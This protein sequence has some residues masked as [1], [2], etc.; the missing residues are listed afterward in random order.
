MSRVRD[1]GMEGRILEAAMKVFGEKGYQET[2]L[3]DIAAGAGISSGSVYTYFKDKQAL[4]ESAVAWGWERFNADLEELA[5][6]TQSFEDRLQA[7]LGRGLAALAQNLS[8]VRGMLF[9]ASK[10]KLVQPGLDRAVDSMDRLLA[11]YFETKGGGPGSKAHQERRGLI[12]IFV[13]GALFSAGLSGDETE[14]AIADLRLSMLSFFALLEN[15]RRASKG[16][17]AGALAQGGDL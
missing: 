3:K 5:A 12:K 6:S 4:F 13:T 10:S 2:T 1:Q 15:Q 9:H 17:P 11:P 14:V 16:L 8:L 7:L